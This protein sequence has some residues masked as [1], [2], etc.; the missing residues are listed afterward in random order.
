M[1]IV[2]LLVLGGSLTTGLII[3]LLAALKLA[4]TQQPERLPCSVATLLNILNSAFFALMLIAALVVDYFGTQLSLISGSIL[5]SASLTGLILVPLSLR[6]LPLLLGAGLG[7]SIFYLSLIQLT[8]VGLLGTS[9]IAA[10]LLFGTV[11]M[12]MGAL[13]AYPLLD[14]LSTAL[15]YRLSL[16]LLACFVLLWGVLAF[17]TPTE[18]LL[19]QTGFDPIRVIT[20]GKLWLAA[21][22]FA[23]YAPLEAFVSVWVT[24]YLTKRDAAT[25]DNPSVDP[26]GATGDPR[27]QA[28]GW[29]AWFWLALLGSRVLLGS[30]LHLSTLQDAWQ[31]FFLIIPAL[32]TAVVFGNLS[33]SSTT[34]QALYGVILLGF[35]LGPVLPTLLAIVARLAIGSALAVALLHIGGAVGGVILSPLVNSGVKERSAASALWIPLFLS[36]ALTATAM[37]FTLSG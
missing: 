1:P 2:T 22:V 33:G 32:M 21:L 24:T 37:F 31:P 3:G 19:F 18:L 30:F 28:A 20:S 12:G 27:D 8:P 25:S 13:L 35:F 29:V 6:S 10:S 14:L 23:F 4:M 5:L 9:A 7:T 17:F 26:S 36:L 15:G 34:R 16:S 11:L